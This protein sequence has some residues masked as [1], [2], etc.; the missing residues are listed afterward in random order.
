MRHLLIALT[1]VS[2]FTACKKDSSETVEPAPEAAAP[3]E[4]AEQA[5][6]AVEPTEDEGKLEV[7]ADV[8]ERYAK[9][10]EEELRIMVEA[11]KEVEALSKDIEGK[12]ELTAGLKA[13]GGANEITARWV[14]EL[15]KARK[16]A[17]FTE[18]QTE[19]LQG[20]VSSVALPRLM[21][22]K[23]G[24]SNETMLKQMRE[25]LGAMSPEDRAEV[26]AQIDE[27]EKGLADLRNAVDARKEYGDAAV[28][29]V[30]QH[31]AK[32]LPLYERLTKRDFGK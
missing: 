3:A 20:L 7:T 30:I 32:L 25:S 9:Y 12:N 18:A 24:S 15:E 10:W 17:G 8:M 19:Y 2:L 5:E 31:E 11:S 16:E 28:D 1:C 4:E 29:A 23:A 13:V 26:K 6:V 21:L 22:A 14:R 27:M